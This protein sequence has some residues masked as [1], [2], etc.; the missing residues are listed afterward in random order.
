MWTKPYGMKEG[1]LL[2]GGLVF[3][4]LMLE[5]TVGQV[6]WDAF[7][8]P[9]NGIVLAFFLI[10]IGLMHLLRKK[11]YAFRFLSTYSAAVPAIIWAVMLT[12]VMGLTRQTVNG[13]WLNN[14]LTFWPFV[15]IYVYMTLI[16]GLVVLKHT[17][18]F[19]LHTPHSTLHTPHPTLHDSHSTLFF[20]LGLFIALTTAT[21]GSA[22]MQRLKMITSVGETEWRAMAQGGEIKEL[23]VA[24]ELKKFIMES[25]ENGSPKRFASEI[26][27]LTQSGKNI[28][29]TIDVN[30]PFEVDGW[31]IYQYGYDTQRG[32][33]SQISI[34]EFVRDPWLPV[35][36]IGIFMMLIGAFLQI[37]FNIPL[38]KIVKI[39]RSHPK[40]AMAFGALMIV[41]FFCIH[42]FMPILHSDT[43][44]PALQSPWFV[45]HI[46]AYMI[47]YTLMGVAALMAIY[48]LVKRGEID[49]EDTLVYIGIGFITIG[50]LF[51]ALWAKEAWGHYWSWDPKETWA[52]ITWFAY[53]GYIHYRR[54]PK[55]NQRIALCTLLVAFALLQMCWW[56]IRFL[57]SAQNA[58]VHIY[59]V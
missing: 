21:L 51:G 30:K 37:I 55:H 48:H 57:P 40:R 36:Y 3:A 44:V 53:L 45:P 34:L 12:I 43:L 6:V 42:H 32:A 15:L 7:S 41:V 5:L 31:K 19:S 59:A 29:T 28:H 39:A 18:Q 54:F 16:L 52:A 56:G 20:H 1:F 23:P 26:Q 13:A 22:D 27:V 4:G 50:M 25:Y 8:W 2:G 46:I 14:M 9:A 11:I 10:L 47:A 38:R 58:S 35:V 49:V 33:Q 24:I 17:S